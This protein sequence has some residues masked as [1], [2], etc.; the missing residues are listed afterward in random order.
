MQSFS[1]RG[2]CSATPLLEEPFLRQMKGKLQ[3][4]ILPL[5]L[6]DVDQICLL[7]DSITD[8][9]INPFLIDR[10]VRKCIKHC[11]ITDGICDVPECLSWKALFCSAAIDNEARS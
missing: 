10:P 2:R 11:E 1:F 5:R 4:K 7:Y 9:K 8:L 6:M 3:G